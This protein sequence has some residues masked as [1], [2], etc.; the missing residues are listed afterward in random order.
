MDLDPIRPKWGAQGGVA[1]PC[2]PVSTG[3]ELNCWTTIVMMMMDKT[4]LV[5]DQPFLVLVHTR[6]SSL[7]LWSFT[8]FS[9]FSRLRPFGFFL[10]CSCAQ[11]NQSINYLLTYQSMAAQLGS[12]CFCS[13]VLLFLTYQ[14]K[15]N[16]SIGL[17][18]A[19]ATEGYKKFSTQLYIKWSLWSIVPPL[20]SLNSTSL[21][22]I[23]KVGRT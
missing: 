22:S 16:I 15:V 14:E 18:S 17:L 5:P 2:P 20:D 19:S 3:P 8:L 10:P 9:F 7:W 12:V 13:A 11:E 4:V 23:L 6:G 1:P 21:I